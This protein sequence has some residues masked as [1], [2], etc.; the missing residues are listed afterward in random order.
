VHSLILAA[1]RRL[2][3]QEAV[4]LDALAKA[5]A[6]APQSLEAALTQAVEAGVPLRIDASGRY[7]LSEPLDWL[8]AARVQAAVA[9]SGLQV[10]V[11]DCCG[12]TNLELRNA[13]RRGAPGGS[14]LAAEWQTQ[15]R[16]RLGRTWHSGPCG[17]LT[18]SLLWRFDPAGAGLD[19]L[20]LALGVAIARGL[21]RHGA[22]VALKWPNDL[23]WRGRKLGGVLIELQ[24]DAAGPYA[25]VIGIGLNVRLQAQERARI[26]QSAADLHEAGGRGVTRNEWL[27]AVLIETAHA[28]RVFE[29]EG[30]APLRDEWTSLHAHAGRR[31]EL[32][33]PSGERREGI[34]A[35]VDESGRLLL[36]GAAGTQAV[37]SGD[38]S[39]RASA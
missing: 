39:L 14:V 12:S 3:H 38:V 9:S 6:V 31:V 25:A 26:D 20:S 16:G 2:S 23:L 27:A 15:G 10:R 37:A 35:G 33:L 21:R 30:F 7:R 29:H 1:L 19:G 36:L 24:S 11:V 32:A 28:L 13:A 5:L 18:F 17:A 34:A 22:S 4:A 8:D